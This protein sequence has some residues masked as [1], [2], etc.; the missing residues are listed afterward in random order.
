MDHIF[1][2]QHRLII[3]MKTRFKTSYNEQ[4]R[5][6]THFEKYEKE[7]YVTSMYPEPL[8]DIV[9]DILLKLR[10]PIRPSKLKA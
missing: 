1:T 8:D 10:I 6:V 3:T 2:T 7:Y 4:V 9:V 5:I